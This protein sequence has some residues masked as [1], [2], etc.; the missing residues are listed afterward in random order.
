MESYLPILIFLLVALAFPLVTLA[1]AWLV[2][3]TSYDRVKMAPYECGIE[4]EEAPRGRYSIRFYVIAVLFVVF[5][6]ETIFLF[7]WAVQYRV[8][9]LFGFIEMA[10][11]LGI[12]VLGYA[13][14]WRRRALEW[15]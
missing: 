1:L 10:V 12:L 4:T 6:V 5:D 14:A 9:G 11:F 8:L 15:V 13:Y 3:P 2:R 7:P